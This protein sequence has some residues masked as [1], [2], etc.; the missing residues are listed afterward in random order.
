MKSTKGN[1]RLFNG[2]LLNCF[3]LLESDE[4]FINLYTPAD[5]ADYIL[6]LF[7]ILRSIVG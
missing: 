1:A 7:Y 3:F 5:V 6:K 4:C 2:P